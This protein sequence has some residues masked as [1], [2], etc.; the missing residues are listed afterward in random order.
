[1]RISIWICV[2]TIGLQGLLQNAL[3]Q[4]YEPDFIELPAA[5]EMVFPPDEALLMTSGGTIEFWVYPAWTSVPDYDPVILSNIGPDGAVYVISILRDKDGL[6]LV[7]GEDE[8]IAPFD[9]SDGRAHHVAVNFY[10]DG[11]VIFVN[12]EVIDIYDPVF[13]SRA[14]SVVVIGSVDGE[15]APFTGSIGA[16]RFWALP[17]EEEMLARFRLKN[18][19]SESEGDHPDIDLLMAISDFENNGLLIV[20]DSAILPSN[21][22]E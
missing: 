17:I 18:V 21:N 13:E 12:G 14:S 2:L 4:S 15:T 5:E 8:I 20:D 6:G 7:L 1:M 10:E 9:F 16:L 22:T 11:T 3:A 19:L